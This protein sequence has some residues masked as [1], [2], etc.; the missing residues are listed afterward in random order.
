MPQGRSHRQRQLTIS[1]MTSCCSVMPSSISFSGP[2]S[3]CT[4]ALVGLGTPLTCLLPSVMPAPLALLL[5]VGWVEV[6]G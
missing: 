4:A 5:G 6:G 3:T 2:S 1:R